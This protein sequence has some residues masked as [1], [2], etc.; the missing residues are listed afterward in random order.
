MKDFSVLKWIYVN[1]GKRRTEGAALI[2]LNALASVCVTLFALLSKTVIDCAGNGDKD[3]LFRNAAILLGLIA[4]QMVCRIFL[5]LLEAASQGRAEI[6]LKTSVFSSILNGEY[7]RSSQ[8]HSGDI[9]TRLTSDVTVVSDA[10]VS[11]LPA[12]VSY[13]VR[14]VSAA[15]ALLA[16]DKSF[17]LIFICCGAVLTVSAAFLRRP[18][19]KLHRRVQEKDGAVRS[20]MQEMTENLFAV[21]VFGIED[22]VRER[23]S[24]LQRSLYRQRIKKKGFSVAASLGFSIAF[25]AGFLAAVSYGSYGIL[26]AT[27]SFGTVAALIQLVNQL[28]SPIMG[29]TGVLPSF[30]AMTASAQ[31]LIEAADCGID[32]EDGNEADY[33]DFKEIRAENIVFGYDG[34]PVLN[35]ASF[36]V[37]KGEFVGIKGPSGAGKTT[38]FKLITGLYRPQ[39]GSISIECGDKSCCPCKGM[40]KLFSVVPQGNMLFSGTIRENL[41]LLSPNAAQTEI[42]GAL[43]NACAEF[44]YTLPEGLDTVLGEGGSGISEGQ[45]QRIAVARALLGGGKII[46]MDEATAALDAETER[47]LIE[48]LQRLDGVTVIFITHREAV[49]EACKKIITVG[50]EKISEKL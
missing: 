26:K 34:E 30:F 14:I 19:K 44:V 48:N 35:G 18:L 43:K 25:A 33:D 13:A 40:R 47:K 39:S 27:M 21:K 17:A 6:S 50:S 8:R 20:F 9:M 1:C 15:A 7:F 38:V 36:T 12:L 46:L 23:S 45:A 29:I 49:L 37:R 32:G 10:S 28:Q 24:V 22:K 4:F 31:R 42:D 41:T 3:G 16:L 11:I 2:V 5:S